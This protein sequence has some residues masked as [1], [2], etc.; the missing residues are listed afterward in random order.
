MGFID[1]LSLDVF[2][3]INQR[4]YQED[5]W[6]AQPVADGYLLAVLDGHGGADVADLAAS[7]LTH[8]FRFGLQQKL[9]E[10]VVSEQEG[11]APSEQHL[12]NNIAGVQVTTDPAQND[13]GRNHR[14]AIAP[15][16]YAARVHEALRA[17]IALLV[18]DCAHYKHVG[19]TLSI[20]YIISA[21]D[22]LK[23]FTAQLG[24]SA[25]LVQTPEG[26]LHATTAQSVMTCQKDRTTITQALQAT[27]ARDNPPFWHRAASLGDQYLMVGPTD[28]DTLGIAV[29]RAIGDS[30]FNGL[31]I[32]SPEIKDFT[33]PPD[34]LI[35][36][37]TDGVHTNGTKDNRYAAYRTIGQDIQAGKT[38]KDIGDTM[39]GLPDLIDNITIVSLRLTETTH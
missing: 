14:N 11:Q 3:S 37:V 30:C 19:T 32:R 23:V 9:P 5:R 26:I 10:K 35:L 24:D 21:G 28:E 31:M 15:D 22:N 38:V 17:T 36:G 39:A 20:A 18:T 8:Y 6:V 13:H 2:Q 27:Q 33:V 1:R 4:A 25:I 29:T 7:R 16:D 34:S 12:I